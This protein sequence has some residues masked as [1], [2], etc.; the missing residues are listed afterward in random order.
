[1]ENQIFDISWLYQPLPFSLT[2]ISVDGLEVRDYFLYNQSEGVEILATAASMEEAGQ[3]MQEYPK[4]KF[5]FK[6]Y[7]QCSIVEAVK[8]I[9][10]SLN[11]G[12]SN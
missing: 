3:L 2:Y 8:Y 4:T 7:N 6:L 9:Q 5:N 11:G 10:N 1:M 12:Q